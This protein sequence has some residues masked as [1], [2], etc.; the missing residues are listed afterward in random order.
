M[1]PRRFDFAARWRECSEEI[2]AGIGEWH[3]HHP[4][5]TLREIEAAVDERLA[6]L[7]ARMLQDGALASQAADVSQTPVQD[8][9]VCLHC[10]T[11]VEPPGAARVAGDDTPG[12]SPALAT[13][14]CALPDL[15]GRVFPPSMRSWGCCR[16]SSPPGCRRVWCAE[17]PG[18]LLRRPLRCWPSLPGCPSQQPPYGGRWHISVRGVDSSCMLEV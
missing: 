9:P 14:L 10:G 8:R 5:A 3:L 11:P 16:S 17:G 12:P 2:M 13:Q 6:E 18:C 1:P 4:K 7:R 15:S